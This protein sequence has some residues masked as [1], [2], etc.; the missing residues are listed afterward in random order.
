[1]AVLTLF[2]YYVLFW[3]LCLFAVLSIGLKTQEEAGEVVPG[4]E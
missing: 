3:W 1:M 4:T 2:A